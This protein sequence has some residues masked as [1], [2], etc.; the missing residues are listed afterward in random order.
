MSG[1]VKVIAALLAHGADPNVRMKGGVT[2]LMLTQDGAS[3]DALVAAGADLNAVDDRGNGVLYTGWGSAIPSR[4]EALTR[5][6]LKLDPEKAGELLSNA[7]A[8]QR[9]LG[10][11]K[12]LLAM[13]ADP[14]AS[15]VWEGRLTGTA[16]SDAISTGEFAIADVL[17]AAGANDVGALSEA[18]AKGDTAKMTALL[19]AGANVDELTKSGRTPLHFAVVQGQTAAVKLLLERG[20]NVNLFD[21]PGYTALALGKSLLLQAEQQHYSSIHRL[22][23]PAAIK[24][25][26]DI[27][28]AIESHKP[29]P[30]YRTASGETALM[31]GATIGSLPWEL[32]KVDINAQQADGMTAL[33][34]AIVTQPKNA[35]HEGPGSVGITDNNNVTQWMSPRAY[36][37]KTLLEKDADLSLRN[38]AGQTAL[39][40]ARQNGNQEILT[41]LEA[42]ARKP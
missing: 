29:D 1:R 15:T 4:L 5:Y 7:I 10:A 13:G 18:A 36:V 6:G 21:N 27:V 35:P 11:V 19:D 20:A 28:E 40:L 39:D 30:N 16:L 14:N 34:L 38:K 12:Q 37:V 22:E 25:L 26:G 2:P 23:P 24:A 32:G 31:R 3:V 17:R 33:M 8:L 9:D 42:A 41:L